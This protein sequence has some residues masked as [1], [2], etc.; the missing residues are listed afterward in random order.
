MK[1]FTQDQLKVLIDANDAP[2]ISVY[3]PTHRRHPDNLQDPIVYRNLI[4]SVEQSL[5]GNFDPAVYQPLL[6]KFSA[7]SHDVE[8]WN[9]RT[10][11]L[12]ILGS[13]KH[14]EVF[15]L[16]RSVQKLAVVAD[17]FHIKP[18]IRMMQATDRYQVLGINR[19]EAKLYEGNQ[20]AIDEIELA[21]GVP[22][23]IE[24]ALGMELTEPHL[25]AAS[26]GGSGGPN[27]GH[28]SPSMHHGHG[29]KKDEVD[30]DNENFFRAIDRAILEHHSRPTNLPLL[31]AA[32][33]EHH[34][35]FRKVS[36]NPFLLEDGVDYDPASIS[37]ERLREE[38]WRVIEPQYLQKLE[39]LKDDYQL[40]A[41][42]QLGSADLSD[43]AKALINGRVSKLMVESGRQIPGRIDAAS[44]KIEFG[45]LQNPEFD[46]LLDDFAELTI[47]MGGE[48][49]VVP[50]EQLGTQT[51]AAAIFRF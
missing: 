23:N 33:P 29:S 15:D 41:S 38:A 18:L 51:G 22:K 10:D 36:H 12:A 13:S 24:E 27:S 25:T 21:A 39:S 9:H 31:I 28:G 42:K 43:I 40:A 30:I 3:L 32:L 26:Y 34:A 7:I 4:R 48:V 50:A 45:E 14:F 17:S 19:H 1:Q 16:Q 2:C 6:E 5:H 35:M 37:N 49:K 8:F 20:D 44:G 47:K 11:G 46:D